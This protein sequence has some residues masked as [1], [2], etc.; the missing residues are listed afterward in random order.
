MSV[1]E[2]FINRTSNIDTNTSVVCDQ[3]AISALPQ[4]QRTQ[5]NALLPII[6]KGTLDPS[7]Y[8]HRPR[9]N[10][11][12]KLR[13]AGGEVIG[14][15]IFALDVLPLEEYERTVQTVYP[16]RNSC[17]VHSHRT[18]R[19]SAHRSSSLSSSSSSSSSS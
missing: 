7:L 4:E 8:C 12:I 10:Y 2:A 6:A 17:S 11:T 5:L 9:K 1:T 19:P 13:D 18:P 15:L 3:S 14:K 16:K